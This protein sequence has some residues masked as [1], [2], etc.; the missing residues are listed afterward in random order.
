MSLAQIPLVIQFNKRDLPDIRTDAELSELA[1]RGGEPVYA[2]VATSGLGVGETLMGLLH[3]TWQ[4]LDQ[5]H[6]L[7]RRLSIDGANLLRSTAKQIGLSAPLHDVL[8]SRL[9]R[10]SPRRA[11]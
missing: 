7:E 3:L 4:T 5:T 9:G 1:T 8:A 10:R 11:P 2:A 6:H